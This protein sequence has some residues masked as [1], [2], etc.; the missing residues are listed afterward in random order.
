MQYDI[1]QYMKHGITHFFVIYPLLLSLVH[2]TVLHIIGLILICT[3][4]TSVFI[5]FYWIYAGFRM[6]IDY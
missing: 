3:V 5:Y 2:L 6:I 4:L 1:C